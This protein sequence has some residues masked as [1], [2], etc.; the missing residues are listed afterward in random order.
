MND[1]YTL[2]KE[3]NQYS[4]EI[5]TLFEYDVRCNNLYIHPKGICSLCR[6]KMDRCKKAL[7]NGGKISTQRKIITF[8]EHSD[9]CLVCEKKFAIRPF[10]VKV[11]HSREQS[12]TNVKGEKIENKDI[13]VAATT[14]GMQQLS[15]EHLTFGKIDIENGIPIIT[16]SVVIEKDYTWKVYIFKK[17]VPVFCDVMKPY[18]CV[19]RKDMH[20]NFL[21]LC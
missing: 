18:P 19:L 15:N 10:T 20:C 11:T 5:K 14:N 17:Q 13:V 9:I 6:K 7:V 8:Q 3:E 21:K 16:K 12:K 1:K 2:I 4:H